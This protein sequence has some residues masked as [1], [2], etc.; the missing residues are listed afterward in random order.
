VPIQIID[1]ETDITITE[2]SFSVLK[3]FGT[4]RFN[5][6]LPKEKEIIVQELLFSLSFDNKLPISGSFVKK[7]NFNA[8]IS[9]KEGFA[10]DK[11]D[12]TANYSYSLA[13]IKFAKYKV[14]D[15]ILHEFYHRYTTY[16]KDKQTDEFKLNL[17]GYFN[18][19]DLIYYTQPVE[20]GARQFS[21][22][23]MEKINEY[24]LDDEL[25]DFIEYQKIKFKEENKNEYKG[26]RKE[27]YKNTDI[28]YEFKARENVIDKSNLQ[29]YVK[30]TE[31]NLNFYLDSYQDTFSIAI[32]EYNLNTEESLFLC[33][34]CKDNTLYINNF[35]GPEAEFGDYTKKLN[36][37]EE[38]LEQV[39]KYY[40][41]KTGK[42]IINLKI[43][44]FLQGLNKN[45]RNR[46]ISNF[47]LSKENINKIS[48]LDNQSFNIDINKEN[49]IL[50]RKIINYND[51]IKFSSILNRL[52]DSKIDEK[53]IFYLKAKL[54]KYGLDDISNEETRKIFKYFV[55]KNDNIDARLSTEKLKESV[56]N[57]FVLKETGRLDDEIAENVITDE[58]TFDEFVK[59]N[60]DRYI[61]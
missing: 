46:V 56:E 38:K 28:L 4:N 44:P 16:H 1:K 53:S 41:N 6:A 61:R 32:E 50:E 12:L 2:K 48:F 54:N 3:A 8:Y 20:I 10:I 37:L 19:N 23:M 21:I 34:T 57:Y 58:K 33:G 7:W 22:R 47:I 59:E 17:D 60:I 45:A 43:S 29:K 25:A 40:E 52:E 55:F 14:L 30:I 36:Y 42:K 9:E 11:S 51:N 18:G 24:F 26:I 13:N 27:G 39:A 15:T 31:N 49:E 5:L 35:Y